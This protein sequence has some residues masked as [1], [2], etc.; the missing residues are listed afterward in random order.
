MVKLNNIGGANGDF[1]IPGDR[2][3]S[4]TDIELT[5]IRNFDPT[6]STGLKYPYES[7]K[8]RVLSQIKIPSANRTVGLAN[9]KNRLGNFYDAADTVPARARRKY[10]NFMRDVMDENRRDYGSPF[11]NN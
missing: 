5:P 7:G 10:G 2:D 6:K 9:L 1:E 4:Q 3:K 8:L 11:S